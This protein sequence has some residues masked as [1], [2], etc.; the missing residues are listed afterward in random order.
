MKVESSSAQIKSDQGLVCFNT[1]EPNWGGVAVEFSIYNKPT[2]IIRYPQNK[3]TSSIVTILQF[4]DDE[5]AN[6]WLKEH[7]DRDCEI[8]EIE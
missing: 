3:G 2:Y 8:I 6:A 4:T 1:W 5:W 7:K